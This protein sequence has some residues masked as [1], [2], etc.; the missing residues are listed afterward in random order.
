MMFARYFGNSV[1]FQQDDGVLQK[2]ILSN[3]VVNGRKGGKKDALWMA[4][5]TASHIG[6]SESIGIALSFDV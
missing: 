3:R 1:Q 2:R 5:F 4:S 6:S